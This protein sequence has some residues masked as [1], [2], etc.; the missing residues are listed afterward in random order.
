MICSHTSTQMEHPVECM[1]ACSEAHL[2]RPPN[3]HPGN[4]QPQQNHQSRNE[5]SLLPFSQSKVNSTPW[6]HRKTRL[7]LFASPLSPACC[8][9][10]ASA[11]SGNL[12]T[13]LSPAAPVHVQRRPP[14]LLLKRFLVFG[15]FALQRRWG[16]PLL[17]CH[18]CRRRL[19]GNPRGRNSRGCCAGTSTSTGGGEVESGAHA[20]E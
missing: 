8:H 1:V 3:L 16:C 6:Q 15:F 4:E 2:V 17:P 20:G 10:S 19:F 9:Q 5:I 18:Q 11:V 14:L 12:S 7:H 13:P